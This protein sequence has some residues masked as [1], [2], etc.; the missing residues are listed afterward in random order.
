M[1]HIE[2]ETKQVSRPFYGWV[3]VA[4]A[5]VLLAISSGLGF[6]N[7]SVI[8]SAAVD[9]L[10]A[11]VGEVSGATGLFFA[12]SGLVGFALSRWIDTLDTRVFLV[13]GGVLGSVA[14]FSLRWVDSVAKLYVFFAFFGVGFALAGLLPVTTLVTRWFKQ[15]RAVALS[16]ASTGLSVG[17]IAVTPIA[18]WLINERSLSGASG[19]M[20]VMWFA[21]IVPISLFLIRSGP[22]AQ[23]DVMPELDGLSFV[24]A[25]RTRFFVGLCAAYGF[26]YL[27]QVG[28]I[29][30]LY[31]MASE[32][33]DDATAATALSALALAS[34]AAR[35]VGGVLALRVS[36]VRMVWMLTAAQAAGL[37]MLAYASTTPSLVLSAA[38]F[39]L[40][41]GN[42]LMLQPLV[43]VEAFGTIA[44]S[45]IYS[46][47]QL[48]GTL[49]VAGG[50]YLLGELRDRFDYRTAFLVAGAASF[51]GF[52]CVLASGSSIVPQR[53]WQEE[54]A[55]VKK[56]V[57][58]T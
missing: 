13:S 55:T 28:G 6:Y 53:L 15:K 46:F 27:G 52:L 8:L 32:R 47:N 45:R 57:N 34:V 17:G 33:T 51:S 50:P 1:A 21:V 25:I 19:L 31:N 41:I 22:D 18:A 12:I 39:G 49:G 30:Q 40:S 48:F 10:D 56:S 35:L 37:G 9:E 24:A 29:A 23:H 36:V 4:A 20:A 16:V 7:A 42:L 58:K 44:Y 2:G 11:T 26:I 43:I 5:F 54:Q 38:F 3:I 14:L